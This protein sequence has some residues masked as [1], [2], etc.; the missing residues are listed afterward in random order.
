MKIKTKV[1]DTNIKRRLTDLYRLAGFQTMANVTPHPTRLAA[2]IVHMRRLK[3]KRDV[4]LLQ[5][6]NE[7]AS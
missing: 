4:F 5:S 6:N 1:F 7:K 3:K 2:I